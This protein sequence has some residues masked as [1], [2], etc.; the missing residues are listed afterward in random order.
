MPLLA[1]RQRIRHIRGYGL[2]DVNGVAFGEEIMRR[3]TESIVKEVAH[4]WATP[5]F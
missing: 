2:K 4:M 5:W 1:L 3:A